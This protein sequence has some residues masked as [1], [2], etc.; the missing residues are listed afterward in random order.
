M[1]TLTKAT[2]KIT[3]TT[4]VEFSKK[5]VWGIHMKA[6]SPKGDDMAVVYSNE[7]MGQRSLRQESGST[8][9]RSSEDMSSWLWGRLSPLLSKGVLLL[10]LL[11]LLVR[12]QIIKLQLYG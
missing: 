3:S 5:Q 9:S 4:V 6:N 10:V 8:T 1:G 7:K 12:Q 11:R 2:G